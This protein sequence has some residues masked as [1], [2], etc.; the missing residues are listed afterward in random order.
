M[1]QN[2]SLFDSL[3]PSFFEITTAM[4]FSIFLKHNCDISIIETGLGGRLDSTNI[5]TPEV[6]VITNIGIDHTN[7]LGT[8]L[9]EIAFEKAGII[10]PKIPVVIGEFNPITF[11]VFQQKSNE[12]HSQLT[13]VSNINKFKT[14]L[15]GIFQQKNINLAVQTIHVLQ[16]NGW[17][18]DK[19]KTHNSLLRIKKNTNFIGRL[20]QISNN[21]RIIIDAS[22]NVDGIK[23]FFTEIKQLKFNK[24]HCIY[25][26]SSDKNINEIMQ[27]FPSSAQYYLTSFNTNRSLNVEYLEKEAIKNNLRQKIFT[28][29]DLA[30][31]AAKQNYNHS[32]LIVVFGSF[33][34]LEKII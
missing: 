20:D 14:D 12:T 7:F 28:T 8:T 31:N 34:L 5:I 26:T 1:C 15:L 2:K 3:N 22:H 32:D 19:Q 33:F 23:N 4:A 16:Q 13:F 30:L 27:L 17:H 24:L 10:K 25:A 29:P 6:S 21:P 9:K 18:I 11:E